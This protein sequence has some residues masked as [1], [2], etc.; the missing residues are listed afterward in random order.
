MM[1]KVLALWIIETAVGLY[2]S[3]LETFTDIEEEKIQSLGKAYADDLRGRLEF[4]MQEM[5]ITDDTPD[6]DGQASDD[7]GEGS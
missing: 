6:A 1:Y 3:I 5:G 7:G 4:W 2:V